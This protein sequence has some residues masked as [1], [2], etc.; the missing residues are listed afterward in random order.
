MRKMYSERLEGGRVTSGKFASGRGDLQGVFTI[1]GPRGDALRLIVGTGYG[2]EH[3]S[4][5]VVG[6][7]R[8]PTWAEMAF[9][10]SLIWLENEAVVQ[11]H[12]PDD[13]YVN[14]HPYVLHLWR[15]IDEAI[16]LPSPALVGIPGIG[17][18]LNRRRAR[19]VRK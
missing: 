11:I 19:R 13:Q 8:C 16:P 5:A 3:V 15:P 18:I 14:N 2:W 9:I 6:K 7:N 10:K 12:P 1:N 17:P 4:V